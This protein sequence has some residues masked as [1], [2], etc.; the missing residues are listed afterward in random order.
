MT[1]LKRLDADD[2]YSNFGWLEGGWLR[3]AMP[4]LGLDQDLLGYASDDVVTATQA[5]CPDFAGLAGLAFLRLVEY[6]GDA[7]EF[8][9]RPGQQKP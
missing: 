1:I 2:H 6:G 8:W 7:D 3:L 9:I 5:S 4:E